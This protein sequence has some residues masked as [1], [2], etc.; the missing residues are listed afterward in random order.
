MRGVEEERRELTV[1]EIIVPV[2]YLIV[3]LFSSGQNFYHSINVNY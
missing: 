1:R 3:S 2:S